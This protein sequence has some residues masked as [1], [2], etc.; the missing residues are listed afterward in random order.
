VKEQKIKYAL[1]RLD[2]PDAKEATILELHTEYS[3][4]N[5]A[6]KE[7]LQ[8]QAARLKHRE[9]AIRLN[10]QRRRKPLPE[11]PVKEGE[12]WEDEEKKVYV[13]RL[14]IAPPK[15]ERWDRFPVVETETET[16]TES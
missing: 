16:E 15:A 9:V 11:A 12:E 3:R 1:V 2:S 4:A 10:H 13:Y 8:R 6:F 5:R 14:A 7:K